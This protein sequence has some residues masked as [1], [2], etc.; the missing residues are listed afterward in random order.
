MSKEMPP[1][2]PRT[3]TSRANMKIDISSSRFRFHLNTVLRYEKLEFQQQALTKHIRP[4]REFCAESA[5][6]QYSTQS[7]LLFNQRNTYFKSFEFY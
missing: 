7:L 2:S 4:K 5:E 1:W 6:I 3:S